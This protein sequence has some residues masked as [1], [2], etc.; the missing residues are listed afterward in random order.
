VIVGKNGSG[1]SNLITALEFI[2]CCPKIEP[3]DRKNY[4][5]EGEGDCKIEIIFDNSLQR[6]KDKNIIIVSRLI[7]LNSDSF[8]LN[9]KLITREEVKGLF[10]SGGI[11]ITS[12]YFMVQ[13]G[14]INSL[15]NLSN[16][17]RYNLIKS[18]A[19][20][21]KYEEDREK[22]LRMLEET[23]QTQSKVE[24]ILER[25]MGKLEG[26]EK[27]KEILEENEE[28]EK[29]KRRYE[30]GY[31]QREIL[32]I[33]EKIEGGYRDGVVDGRDGGDHVG[34]KGVDGRIR[35]TTLIMNITLI[36]MI[37]TWMTFM[38]N[39][40]YN[41]LEKRLLKILN[42]L[43]IPLLITLPLLM[44]LRLPFYQIN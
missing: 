38:L 34:Y 35:T 37:F 16:E 36:I 9:S 27:D 33:N 6:I 39:S 5:H 2:I 17:Q 43:I 4:I 20:I 31:K 29:E 13:Q 22:S 42:L 8:Y 19:G 12:P 18:I 15:I 10:E 40:N 11:P 41:K 23:Q 28:L 32:E 30:I 14:K 44:N 24:G 25:I 1:K 21:S 26:L 3:Q 7:N